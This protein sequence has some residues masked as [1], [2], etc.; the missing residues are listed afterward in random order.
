MK[1]FFDSK[2]PWIV[3]SIILSVGLTW[4]WRDNV[5]RE[6]INEG[7]TESLVRIEPGLYGPFLFIIDSLNAKLDTASMRLER[8]KEASSRQ[9]H[10]IAFYR[11]QIAALERGIEEGAETIPVA[12]A[13]VDTV[14]RGIE[15]YEE[16][17][18]MSYSVETH[19]T[20]KLTYYFPPINQ[21]RNIH[22]GLQQ[23]F[24]ENRQTIL[25][26]TVL[27]PE[28]TGIQLHHEIL[29]AL[30]VGAMVYGLAEKKPLVAGVGAGGIVLRFTLPQLKL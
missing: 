5:W 25:T 10:A 26:K 24:V 22:L 2:A 18:S 30:S 28:P 7:A 13:S 16:G 1:D 12:T 19:D 15:W 9:E 23:R 27:V 17:D 8:S 6:R 3:L 20:L 11:E 21:F 29:T 14:I 4:Y